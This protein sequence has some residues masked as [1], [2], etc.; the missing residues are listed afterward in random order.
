M[1][2]SVGI[3]V[4][5]RTLDVAI[6]GQ[7]QVVRLAN[8]PTGWGELIALLASISQPCIVL[9]ATNR[10]HEGVVAALG[11]TGHR[12][13]VANPLH[14]AAFRRSEATLAKTDALD[15]RL[16]Q[17]FAAQKHPAPTPRP[18]PTQRDVRDLGRTREDLVT[19]RT[20]LT[21]QAGV[22]PAISAPHYAA[23]RTPLAR[24]ITHLDRQIAA[25]IAQHPAL[26]RTDALLQSL[27]GLGPVSSACLLG[28]LPELGT[29]DRRQIASL[30]GLAP[31]NH[32]SGRTVHRPTVWGGR[33]EIRRC[34][35]LVALGAIQR[36]RGTQPAR[37]AEVMRAR[38]DALRA[39]GKPP[40]LAVIA[41]G[42][43][44]L[45]ILN[46]MVRDGLRWEETRAA[47][48]GAAT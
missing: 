19:L 8:T 13:T 32:Q 26:A 44:L 14:T 4:G 6:S 20:R 40:R 23:I 31:R 34:L 1:D 21:L 27:P 2:A 48:E 45:T 30:G 43:W 18:D 10:Y 33:R 17:R 11:E 42:R 5:K 15:A 36:R 29:L 38:Y 25:T 35:Y 37:G 41:L 24:Q 9:E 16:L 46:V 3:D 28:N 7:R 22:M 12:V 47:Q 39:Q